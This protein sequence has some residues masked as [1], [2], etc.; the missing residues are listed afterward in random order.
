MEIQNAAQ[1]F[2]RAV[3]AGDQETLRSLLAEDVTLRLF[4][5]EGDGAHRPRTF[6]IEALA[7]VSASWI[8]RSLDLYTV[9]AS[10]QT[11]AVQFRTQAREGLLA[12]DQNGGAF[13]DF[14]EGRVGTV[15]LYLSRP[16]PAAERATILTAS[17]TP[18]ERE[19][20]I[21][22]LT[23]R[24]DMRESFPANSRFSRTRNC[25]RHW[26][27]IAHPGS[28]QV[29]HVRWSAGEADEKIEETVA[30]F[31]QRGLGFQWSIGPYDQPR[32]LGDRLLRHGFLRAGDQALMLR[33]GIAELDDIPVN[34]EI[35]VVDL[36]ARPDLWEASLQITATAFHWPPQQTENA[37]D[38]W[39]E[40]L[41]SARIRSV[42]AL[43]D[44]AP[45]A[46][47]HLYLQGGVAYLGGAATL[48]AH[49]ARKIYST[50]LRRRLER[51]RD[52]GY[53]VAML[54]AEP[55]SRRVVSRF[56]FETV[57]MYDVYGWMEPMDPEV[58]RRL[59]VDD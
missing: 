14:V 6:V 29:I 43:L 12:V 28:N 54:H 42:M 34:S 11:A 59:V 46:D 19:A 27:D 35:E 9:A 7:A 2:V 40:D 57:A 39:F 53:Q 45:V 51:A 21:E 3:A 30:W 1:E 58:I 44:G 18:A 31:R 22:S 37:R 52:E 38:G 33:F 49:R 5:W 56:G 4:T 36:Q 48:P 17:M 47:G 26:T 24:W 10:G 20:V 15:D 8:S 13:L 41:K 50:L 25:T 16:M 32:D 23:H 55:M